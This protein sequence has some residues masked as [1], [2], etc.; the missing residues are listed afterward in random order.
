MEVK[1][2]A[3]GFLERGMGAEVV[4]EK[5]PFGFYVVEVFWS[6]VSPY[7]S[8]PAQYISLTQQVLSQP[9]FNF[10]G[11]VEIMCKQA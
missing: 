10:S 6:D 11:V 4:K 9:L 3:Q 5:I 2:N 7:I 1:C 8:K